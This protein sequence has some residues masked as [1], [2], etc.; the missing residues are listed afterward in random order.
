MLRRL[1][2]TG[3]KGAKDEGDLICPPSDEGLKIVM[4]LSNYGRC[5]QEQI[6]SAAVMAL[7]RLGVSEEELDAIFDRAVIETK[8]ICEK[9]PFPCQEGPRIVEYVMPIAGAT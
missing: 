6:L 8:K 4:A 7:M 9:R 2:V 3:E 5:M 1:N